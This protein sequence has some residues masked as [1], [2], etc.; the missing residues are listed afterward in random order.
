MTPLQKQQIQDFLKKDRKCKSIITQTVADS[1]L[2]YIKDKHTAKEMWTALQNT[3]ARKGIRNQLLLRKQL[4]QLKLE[5]RGTLNLH[6]LTFDSIVRRFKAS[7][8]TLE[9][10]D[11]ICRL[12]LTLPK[13]YE[14]VIT[15]IETIAGSDLTLDFV[16][17]KL[18]DEE[19]KQK[20][21]SNM[22]QENFT[23]FAG[24]SNCN[25]K[26]WNTSGQKRYTKMTNKSV[27]T[28]RYF[29]FK[30]HNCGQEGHKRAECRR[31]EH[32]DSGKKM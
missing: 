11:I 7:G 10:N 22:V 24:K 18:L 15:T 31:K 21:K 16:K 1:H 13:S 14:M 2:E 6:F 29:R 17:G 23:A 12:L 30:C 26:K 27:N 5:E 3:F 28:G 25:K 19:I 20:S 4:L 32:T 8:D 9:K